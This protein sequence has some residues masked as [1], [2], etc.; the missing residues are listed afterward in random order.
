MCKIKLC[1]EHILFVRAN[2]VKRSK[3]LFQKQLFLYQLQLDR[4]PELSSCSGF[5]VCR[6]GVS[7]QSVGS[8]SGTTDSG[9]HLSRCYCL[10][11]PPCQSIQEHPL[12][13]AVRPT[14]TDLLGA[15]CSLVLTV[16]KKQKE[17]KEPG[18]REASGG[19]GSAVMGGCSGFRQ[20]RH[21]LR[22]RHRPSEFDE[23][24]PLSSSS[25]DPLR[26]P[27]PRQNGQMFPQICCGSKGSARRAV[28]PPKQSPSHVPPKWGPARG[29]GPTGKT[30][31]V[32]SQT[33]PKSL[34]VF[35]SCFSSASMRSAAFLC[36]CNPQR[37]LY[38]HRF[39]F[40][41]PRPPSRCYCRS[42]ISA[43]RSAPTKRACASTR[44]SSPWGTSSPER[45]PMNSLTSQ[46]RSQVAGMSAVCLGLGWWL[47][48][49]W[50][51]GKEGC[52]STLVYAENTRK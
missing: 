3:F 19:E 18:L 12:T 17:K 13:V 46:T 43:G 4:C 16:K 34:M 39:E 25:S 8:V 51:R 6:F 36:A 27:L 35:S 28:I 50:G 2:S 26:H 9:D 22:S 49:E 41:W 29:P 30:A 42:P 14:G 48:G 37:V 31:P 20:V 32:V 47:D 38:A 40:V 10:G 52:T 5:G 33:E 1:Q 21:H 7:V 15:A 45:S 11:K 24:R 44:V 23:P